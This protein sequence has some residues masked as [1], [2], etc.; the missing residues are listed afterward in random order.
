[1]LG[2]RTAGVSLSQSSMPKFENM[3]PLLFSHVLT[4]MRKEAHAIHA[5]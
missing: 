4:M 2:E 5:K 1:M 3:I